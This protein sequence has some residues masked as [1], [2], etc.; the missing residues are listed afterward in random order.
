MGRNNASQAS[1]ATNTSFA[2]ANE[3]QQ[4]DP[5]TPASYF[6]DSS[7]EDTNEGLNFGN[8]PLAVLSRTNTSASDASTPTEISFN[9]NPEETM[10][11]KKSKKTSPVIAEAAPAP[12]ITA[13]VAK[14]DP[15]AAAKPE[16]T[17]T[18][19]GA[20]F[21]VAQNVYGWTKDVWAWGTTV[22]VV[23]NLLGITEAVAAKVVDAAL[24]TDL[25]AIDQDAVV[26]QLKKLDDGVVNPV[27][28]AVWKIIEPAMQKA[29]EMVVKP[30]MTEVVPR[31][32]APLSMFDQKKKELEAKKKEEAIGSSPAPEIIPALN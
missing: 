27:I 8:D 12:I 31:M 22:P 11:S 19:E 2:T 28:L 32:L 14:E 26:P 17:P 29:E 1:F 21:D 30:V 24:H 16:P 6:V 4:A 3:S 20:H 18:D 9:I 5:I 7:D 25:P 13:P 10:P 15:P 23:S